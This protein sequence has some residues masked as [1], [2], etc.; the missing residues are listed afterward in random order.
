[1]ARPQ[2]ARTIISAVGKIADRF[3]AHKVY[4]LAGGRVH[5]WTRI[6]G[7][8]AVAHPTY[9]ALV[10]MVEDEFAANGYR[11]DEENRKWEVDDRC[12]LMLGSTKKHSRWVAELHIYMYPPA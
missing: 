2:W 10:R 12:P 4:H 3:H 8:T 7:D 9:N 11:I 5:L 1:M 6:S